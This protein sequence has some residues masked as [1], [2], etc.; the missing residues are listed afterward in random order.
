MRFLYRIA[1][2]IFLTIIAEGCKMHL[3]LLITAQ[4]HLKEFGLALIPGVDEY[5]KI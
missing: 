2:P 4:I 3:P 5:E 1:P